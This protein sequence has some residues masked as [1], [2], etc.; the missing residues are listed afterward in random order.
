MSLAY[1]LQTWPILSTILRFFSLVLSYF[2]MLNWFRN[3]SLAAIRSSSLKATF[4]VERSLF[5]HYGYY[6]IGKTVI[7]IWLFY[8]IY[9]PSWFHSKIKLSF[10]YLGII[11]FSHH[12]IFWI[13][14]KWMD[15]CMDGWVVGYRRE[16]LS[17]LFHLIRCEDDT[18]RS[19]SR[20]PHKKPKWYKNSL[21]NEYFY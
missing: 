5:Y 20:I 3:V 18:L 11:T 8:F 2:A 10:L 7:W 6:D 13:Y 21:Q 12:G 19:K 14:C 17:K 9:S 15:W 16:C 1:P 4:R